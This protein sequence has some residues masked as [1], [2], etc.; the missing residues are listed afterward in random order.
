MEIDQIAED[1]GLQLFLIMLG[2]IYTDKIERI[3]AI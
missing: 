1:K 2:N 3:I